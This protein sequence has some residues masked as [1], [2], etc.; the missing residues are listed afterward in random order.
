MLLDGEPESESGRDLKFCSS[1]EIRP[2]QSFCGRCRATPYCSPACAAEHWKGRG[3]REACSPNT[4]WAQRPPAPLPPLRPYTPDELAAS[5]LFLALV[6]GRCAHAPSDER[7][8]ACSL[9]APLSDNALALDGVELDALRN[10]AVASVRFGWGAVGSTLAMGYSHE[11]QAVLRLFYGEG[12]GGIGGGLGGGSCGEGEGSGL[13]GGSSTPAPAPEEVNNVASCF[14]NFNLGGRLHTGH[15]VLCKLSRTYDAEESRF[16]LAPVRLSI[17]EVVDIIV[18]RRHLGSTRAHP[19]AIGVS[20]R[21][22]RENMRRCERKQ[23]LNNVSF[24]NVFL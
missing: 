8:G 3:H 5:H 17:A 7:D 16:V 4:P 14:V 6:P 15:Y 1:C 24:Q 12:G 13:G 18:W 19:E 20:T 9:L 2:A 11:D 22:H 10:E 21:V 23:A